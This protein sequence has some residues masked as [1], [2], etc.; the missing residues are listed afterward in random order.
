MVEET[1]NRN[2][3]I[4]NKYGEIP[5]WSNR[6]GFKLVKSN[7]PRGVVKSEGNKMELKNINK[8]NLKE[9]KEQF[10]KEKNNAEVDFAKAEMRRAT[11]IINDFDRQIKVLNERKK[12]CQDILDNFKA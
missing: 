10:T 12:L 8:K 11:D 9:A 6:K 4:S 3:K 5:Q 7:I 1:D 2:Y